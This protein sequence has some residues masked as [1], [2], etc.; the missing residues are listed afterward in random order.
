MVARTAETMG[1]DRLAIGSDL[2]QGQPDSV[3]EWMRSG[4]WTK[5]IDFGEGS[6]TNAGFPPQPRWFADNT[7]FANL[8][9][10]LR[11]AGFSAD[12]TAKILGGNWLRFFETSFAPL[13]R[14]AVATT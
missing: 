12:D 9:I 10:G 8:R 3:V 2:C 13:D 7:G 5:G 4:R 14:T 1:I 11:E 6:A